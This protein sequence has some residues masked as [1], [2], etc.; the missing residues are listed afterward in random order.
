MKILLDNNVPRLLRNHL[1]G[2]QVDAALQF[3]WHTLSNGELLD[4][5][6]NEGYQL[7]ITADQRIPYQQNLSR[8]NIAVLIITGNRRR[9]VSHALT[10]INDAVNSMSPEKHAYWK[11]TQREP[12]PL[13]SPNTTAHRHQPRQQSR[14]KSTFPQFWGQ[15]A[16]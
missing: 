1:P 9:H 3:S 6:E 2:H 7:L 12:R 14:A 10:P 5:A 15:A 8:R 13:F 16:Q 11:S 4:R